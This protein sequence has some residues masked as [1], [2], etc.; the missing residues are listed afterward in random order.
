MPL[1]YKVRARAWC[2][3]FWLADRL[4]WF[5]RRAAP[6]STGWPNAEIFYD[7]FQTDHGFAR[8][9]TGVHQV[10]T[11]LEQNAITFQAVVS[12]QSRRHVSPH[13]LPATGQ[14]IGRRR[15]RAGCVAS[16]TPESFAISRRESS[17]SSWLGRIVINSALMQRRCGLRLPDV[18]PSL[19]TWPTNC[20][21]RN[22]ARKNLSR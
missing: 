18:L 6:R 4:P 16:C 15:R 17:L 9:R 12:S 8:R 19:R 2:A 1:T 20:A 3:A 22:R 10:V 13:G 14:C 7:F 11:T 5:P 21:I